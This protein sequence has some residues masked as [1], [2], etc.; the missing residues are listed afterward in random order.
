MSL[1]SGRRIHSNKWV[2][3]PTTQVQIN[4][5][6]ELASDGGRDYWL[7]ELAN[8]EGNHNTNDQVGTISYMV[9]DD[10]SSNLDEQVSIVDTATCD[11]NQDLDT[12]G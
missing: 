6:H 2:E 4:R 3:M 1:E 8:Y 7:D 11:G 12:G 5:V 10:N 9:H